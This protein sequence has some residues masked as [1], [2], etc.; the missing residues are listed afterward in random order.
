MGILISR[1]GIALRSVQLLLS[2]TV[3]LYASTCVSSG[4]TVSLHSM[5]S[6]ATFEAGLNL[7]SHSGATF[8]E[9]FKRLPTMIFYQS[10]TVTTTLSLNV[11]ATFEEGNTYLILHSRCFSVT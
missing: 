10:F 3:V 4:Y 2:A 5:I 8:L 7:Y 6:K 9:G 11:S 1:K